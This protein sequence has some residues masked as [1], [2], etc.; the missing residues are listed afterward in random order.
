MF[1]VA[2]TVGGQGRIQLIV[3][4]VITTRSIPFI[5]VLLGESVVLLSNSWA[6]DIQ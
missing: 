5:C 2:W 3:V 6:C 4:G 1:L